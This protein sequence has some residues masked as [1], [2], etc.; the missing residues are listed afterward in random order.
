MLPGTGQDFA[1]SGFETV[2]S[3]VIVRTGGKWRRDRR[4]R[5]PDRAQKQSQR[6]RRCI[7]AATPSISTRTSGSAPPKTW[8][9]D[10]RAERNVRSRHRDRAEV[11]ADAPGREPGKRV[12]SRKAG[13]IRKPRWLCRIC[14]TRIFSPARLVVFRGLPGLPFGKIGRVV[15]GQIQSSIFRCRP[16]RPRR[17]DRCS[18]SIS[19]PRRHGPTGSHSGCA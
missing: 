12:C 15:N 3:P 13:C 9:S 8:R 5:R 16:K 17:S 14:R 7:T 18:S 10:G 6:D 11:R 19:G 4:N 1:S 2:A